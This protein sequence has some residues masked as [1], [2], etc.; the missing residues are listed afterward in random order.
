MYN[1][2]METTKQEESL[3]PE[4]ESQ[5][6]ISAFQAKMMEAVKEFECDLYAFPGFLPNEDGSFRAVVNIQVVD[7]RKFAAKSPYQ[8]SDLK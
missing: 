3:T 4:Q 5:K 7:T 6:R 1:V 2:F 8:I